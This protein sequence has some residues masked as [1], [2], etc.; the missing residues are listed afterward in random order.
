MKTFSKVLIAVFVVLGFAGTTMAATTPS[1][2]LASSY[3]V[4]AGTYT[5]P[6]GTTTIN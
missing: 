3:G 5:N 2:G 6:A 4:L 1:L